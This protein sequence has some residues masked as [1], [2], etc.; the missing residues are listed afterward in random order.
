[1]PTTIK[2]FLSFDFIIPFK[3][4][5][6]R[7]Q[8]SYVKWYAF[9]CSILVEKWTNSSFLPQMFPL[10]VLLGEP[11]CGDSF[12]LVLFFKQSGGRYLINT[13]AWI[14]QWII[15][16]TLRHSSITVEYIFWHAI[17]PLYSISTL[18][19]THSL[20]QQSTALFHV[21]YMYDS[22]PLAQSARSQD[23]THLF[24]QLCHFMDCYSLCSL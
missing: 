22:G 18:T 24:S 13:W 10:S 1:M 19:W 11:I 20:I 21:L 7:N 23:K 16:W 8:Y 14:H 17:S 9:S 12:F 2:H 6:C 5:N 3:G 15:S 4:K